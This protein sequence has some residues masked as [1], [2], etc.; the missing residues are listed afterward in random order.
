MPSTHD[1]AKPWDDGTVDKWAEEV[2][3][4]EDNVGGTLLEESSFA[5]LFP[6]CAAFSSVDSFS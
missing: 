3:K 6:K 2:F 4:P 5:T 1:K